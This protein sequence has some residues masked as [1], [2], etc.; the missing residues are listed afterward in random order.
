M[1]AKELK[2]LR[3]IF[4][5]MSPNDLEYLSTT[6]AL[7]AEAQRSGSPKGVRNEVKDVLRQVRQT[8]LQLA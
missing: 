1:K 8:A 7:A 5:A 4:V 3:R 6:F 2:R